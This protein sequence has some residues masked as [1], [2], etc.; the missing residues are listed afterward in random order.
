MN[1]F[2]GTLILFAKFETMS[3]LYVDDL[4]MRLTTV[5]YYLRFNFVG[6]LAYADDIVCA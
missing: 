6:V 1:I 4:M 3:S 5:G 2:R